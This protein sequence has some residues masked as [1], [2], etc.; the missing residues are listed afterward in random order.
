[1]LGMGEPLALVILLLQ[2]GSSPRPT[3]PDPVTLA[4]GR[5]CEWISQARPELLPVAQACEAALQLQDSMPNFVCDLKVKRTQVVP[6]AVS[7]SSALFRRQDV[8]TAE[9]TY[10]NGQEQFGNVKLNGTG[11][12][13]RK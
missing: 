7:A 5:N 9:V 8:V 6:I 12:C 3:A 4:V 2:E 13:A 11:R 1:M 10:L